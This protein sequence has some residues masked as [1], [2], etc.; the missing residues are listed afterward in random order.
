MLFVFELE[1]RLR[2]AGV[3]TMA[4]GCHPGLVGIGLGSETVLHHLVMPLANL[5]LNT[6]AI[7]AGAHCTPRLGW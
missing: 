3:S 7:G 5:V 6:P 4:V 1:R 2:A